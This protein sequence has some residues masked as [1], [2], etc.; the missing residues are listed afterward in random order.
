MK[1]TSLQRKTY[2]GEWAIAPAAPLHHTPVRPRT[3]ALL[4]NR[5]DDV[6]AFVRCLT[7]R[8]NIRCM[9]CDFW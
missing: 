1:V 7:L 5:T 8:V 4:N 9:F 3:A 2:K 6:I